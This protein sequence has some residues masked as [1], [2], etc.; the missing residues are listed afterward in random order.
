[1]DLGPFGPFGPNFYS[2]VLICKFQENK[3]ED[4]LKNQQ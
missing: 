4:Q 2:L 1:L 3:Q